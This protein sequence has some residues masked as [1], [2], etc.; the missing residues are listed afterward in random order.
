M[1]EGFV[2]RSLCFICCY[3]GVVSLRS[4]PI[5]MRSKDWNSAGSLAWRS[6]K[7]NFGFKIGEPK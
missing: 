5:L 4:V 2:I 7:S 6:S 3:T 1:I